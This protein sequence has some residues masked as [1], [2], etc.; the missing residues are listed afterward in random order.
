MAG[1]DREPWFQEAENVLFLASSLL[2]A[3]GQKRESAAIKT[4]GVALQVSRHRQWSPHNI[5]DPERFVL[6]NED[7]IRLAGAIV[8][9]LRPLRLSW[10]EAAVFYHYYFGGIDL[11]TL[12][13]LLRQPLWEV[14]RARRHLV[15]KAAVVL[16]Y[17]ELDESLGAITVDLPMTLEE[18]TR[19][20]NELLSQGLSWKE[21]GERLGADPWTLWRYHRRH[22]EPK[23]RPPSRPPARKCPSPRRI[24]R[25]GGECAETPTYA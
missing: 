13:S 11:Q 19:R 15:K 16:G 10:L 4:S 3:L 18:R 7:E 17:I 21:I 1:T 25:V 5:S 8:A 22:V 9:A 14:D 24:M 12:A 2:S 20:V 6:R 23:E